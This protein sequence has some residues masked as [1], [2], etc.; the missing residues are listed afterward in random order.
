MLD[1]CLVGGL[2]RMGKA[3]CSVAQKSNDTR[4]VSVWEAAEAIKGVSDFAHHSGYTKNQVLLTSQGE[5][6]VSRADVILDFSTPDAFEM[7]IS[8]C[9]KLSKPLVT[10]TTGIARK[11]ERLRSL[12]EKVAVVSAPNMAC[13]VNLFLAACEYLARHIPQGTDVEIVETHHRG[14]KDVPSGTALEIAR[15]ISRL[16]SGQ[17]VVGRTEGSQ[18]RGKEIVVHSL[19]MGDVPGIHSV[20][21]SLQ[22]ETIE[23]KHTALSRE[24]F[25]AGALQAAHF[26]SQS[27]PGLYT[28]SDVLGLT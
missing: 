27:P 2:G 8:V 3:I 25:A 24:C 10:G 9:E 7:I 17:I 28:M 14:K 22:G 5:E 6:A 19:R 13:G 4:I 18:V 23:F 16:L 1:I 26:V 12:S 15:R 20:L 11:E 21:Y